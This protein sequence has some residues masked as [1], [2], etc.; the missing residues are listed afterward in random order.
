[1]AP[2]SWL[3]ILLYYVNLCVYDCVKLSNVK[4]RKQLVVAF[5]MHSTL[6]VFIDF[7]FLNKV[8]YEHESR[9]K[10]VLFLPNK[11]LNVRGKLSGVHFLVKTVGS[12]VS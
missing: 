12:T 5:L 4:H 6:V 2:Y 8:R 1:M 9:D 10:K 11:Q 3:V 7:S